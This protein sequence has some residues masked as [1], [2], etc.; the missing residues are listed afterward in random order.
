MSYS[1]PFTMYSLPDGKRSPDTFVTES[2][3]VFN[4]AIQIIEAGFVFEAEV[5]RTNQLHVTITDDNNDWSVEIISNPAQTVE[6]INNM[7][8]SFDIDKAV[9]LSKEM[10]KPA[11]LTAGEL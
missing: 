6:I 2:E 11:T 4:K 10:S 8:I 7:I 9:H 5:L 3:N 1:I